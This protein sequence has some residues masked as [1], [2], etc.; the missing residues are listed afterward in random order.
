MVI[1]IIIYLLFLLITYLIKL[2]IIITIETTAILILIW[3]ILRHTELDPHNHSV[4]FN[5]TSINLVIISII[6]LFHNLFLLEI[7]GCSSLL[8]PLTM[9]QFSQPKWGAHMTILFTISY[10]LSWYMLLKHAPIFV[11]WFMI[12]HLITNM[13]L[14]LETISS[15]PS[16]RLQDFKLILEQLNI[17]NWLIC[18]LSEHLWLQLYIIIPMLYIDHKCTKNMQQIS[19]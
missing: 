10:L 12:A 15:K 14:L 11:N 5:I 19:I 17:I 3:C 1:N 4:I 9:V 7:I 16:I 8:I 6:L 18:I 2:P 13:N